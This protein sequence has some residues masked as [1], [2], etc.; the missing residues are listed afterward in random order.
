MRSAKGWRCA[1]ALNQNYLLTIPKFDMS[2]STGMV[3]LFSV[4]EVLDKDSQKFRNYNYEKSV[5]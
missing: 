5:E 4:D 3:Y 2:I 1:I